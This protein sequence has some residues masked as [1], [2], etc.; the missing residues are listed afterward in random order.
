MKKISRLTKAAPLILLGLILG[1]SPVNQ[2]AEALVGGPF[3]DNDYNGVSADGTYSAT[4]TGTNLIGI[5]SF[6]ISSSQET[7]G[8]FSVF[9]EGFV[10]Y[11]A[12]AGIVDLA[13]RRIAGSLLGVAALGGNGNGGGT[14]E[15]TGGSGNL[16]S[17][18]TQ[19]L[20]HRS[21]VEG[22]FQARMK[23]YP[24]TVTFEGE[25]RLSSSAN[26]AVMTG[27]SNLVISYS[28]A[29]TTPSVPGTLQQPPSTEDVNLDGQLQ[30]AQLRSQT[31]FKVRG[32]RTS[33]I[34]YTA[35]TNYA[36]V[37]PTLPISGT[38]TPTPATP[39]PAANP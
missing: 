38:P 16:A 32:S 8:R 4:L 6:G 25:G 3:D 36:S 1:N 30:V 20:T 28:T 39:T 33:R 14:T 12:A 26:N 10:H 23:G 22:A 17:T 29:T 9:H 15:T 2:R 11:G 21:S 31:P 18:S 27:E 37:P 19:T 24:Q 35:T 5:V 7:Q 34:V 13:S